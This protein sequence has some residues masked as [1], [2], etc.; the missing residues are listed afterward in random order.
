M[1]CRS[2]PM[3]SRSGAV[4]PVGEGGGVGSGLEQVAVHG[5]AVV[6]V[7]LGLVAHRRPLRQVA[8]EQTGAVES[9]EGGDG[10]MSGGEHPHQE[11]PAAS[12]ARAHRGPGPCGR[13]GSV[14]PGR[15]AGCVRPP[16]RPGGG[17]GTG[18]RPHRHPRS[19]RPLAWPMAMPGSSGRGVGPVAAFGLVAVA[20]GTETPAPAEELCQTLRRR[21]A[22][23]P[24]Q[25]TVRPAVGHRRA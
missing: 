8:L 5:E 10:R 2:V 22:S 19:G 12:R 6:R 14:R 4:D 24:S 23:S 25:A 15:W 9:L 16:P 11:R 3:S 20:G 18:R 21:Q 17:P 1:S 13:A 7:A